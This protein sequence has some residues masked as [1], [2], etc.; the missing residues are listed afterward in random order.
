MHEELKQ[1]QN[2]EGGDAQIKSELERI[3]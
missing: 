2:A 3:S 1:Q